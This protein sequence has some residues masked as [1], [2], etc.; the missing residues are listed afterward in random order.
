M[1]KAVLT[2]FISIL[3]LPLLAG[4]DLFALHLGCSFASETENSNSIEWLDIETASD[5]NKDDKKF[6]FIDIYTDWCGWCKKMDQSTFLDS[7]VIE[8]MNE[9]FYAVK[10]NAESKEPVAYKEVLYE[11]KMYNGKGYN[12]LA[13]NL[14]SGKMSFPSFVILSKKEVRLGTIVGFQKPAEL[15]DELKNYT[16]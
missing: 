8:Y 16:N 7:S 4:A 5:R 1:V 2:G 11:Y 12:E 9:H 13:V 6:F 14:L 15:L 3:T 10:M